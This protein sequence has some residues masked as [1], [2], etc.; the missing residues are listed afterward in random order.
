MTIITD[1]KL[2]INDKFEKAISIAKGDPI[3]ED[4]IEYKDWKKTGKKS[5]IYRIGIEYQGRQHDVPVE[6]FGGEEG[7][8]KG[9]ERDIRKKELFV[10]N[11]A[12]LIEVRKGYV[13]EDVVNK[14]KSIIDNS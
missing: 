8:K 4:T 2:V 11:N 9:K 7:F 3:G 5:P 13:F 12:I 1:K 10:E 6:F 14:I